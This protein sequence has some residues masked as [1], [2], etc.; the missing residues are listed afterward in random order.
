[1]TTIRPD[2]RLLSHRADRPDGVIV[3]AQFVYKFIPTIDASFK[4]TVNSL[5]RTFD[6]LLQSAHATSMLSRTRVQNIA[7]LVIED[8]MFGCGA[9]QFCG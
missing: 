5:E 4:V 7:V 9:R 3:D 1:M 6:H 8:D 2:D